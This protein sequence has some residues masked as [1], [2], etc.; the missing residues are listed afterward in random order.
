[1]TASKDEI[2]HDGIAD[3]YDYLVVRPRIFTI[4]LLFEGFE[5]AF[6]D[7]DAQ[8]DLGCGTG[9]ML[10]RYARGFRSALGVDHSAGML[11]SAAANL[12]A[13]GLGHAMLLKSDL[14]GF[15]SK[16]HTRFDLITCVGVL[17]HLEPG[18]RAELLRQ[19]RQLCSPQGRVLLAEPVETDPFPDAVAAW[20]AAALG[21]QRSY[22]G[23]IPEDPDEAPLDEAGWRA[24]I[25]DAGWN[26]Q[27]ESRMWEMSTTL[28][29]P[30]P[31]ERA[32]IRQLVAEHPGGNVLALLLRAA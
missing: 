30:G 9:H 19:M 23:E 24:A 11:D 29:H 22:H 7:R 31:S 21:G 13:A 3:Q 5:E 2:Y 25:G 26:V 27:A 32:R 28:E 12:R 20:N 15:A 10:L 4:G 14:L 16:C 17:H 18:P 6:G 1:M 8:L